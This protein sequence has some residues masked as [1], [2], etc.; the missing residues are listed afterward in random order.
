MRGLAGILFLYRPQGSKVRSRT[1]KT[2]R[3]RL[4]GNETQMLTRHVDKNMTSWLSLVTQ[5]TYTNTI[6]WRT[7][8]WRTVLTRRSR[9]GIR[10]R[11][12]R[13]ADFSKLSITHAMSERSKGSWPKGGRPVQLANLNPRLYLPMPMLG[14]M[15]RLM[16][17]WPDRLSST[18]TTTF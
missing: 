9:R 15:L 12:R 5:L 4:E 17:P 10:T 13:H 3:L 14:P 18:S 6:R 2:H 7:M 11:R 1:E 8:S 16:L